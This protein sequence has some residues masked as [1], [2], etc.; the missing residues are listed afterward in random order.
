[1]LLLHN[2]ADGKQLFHTAI[3]WRLLVAA[4]LIL[5]LITMFCLGW[6]KL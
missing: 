1:M 5:L 3:T 4:F 6:I 2:H